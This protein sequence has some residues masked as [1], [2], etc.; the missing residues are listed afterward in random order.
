[1][2][3]QKVVLVTG[4]SSGLGQAAAAFLAQQSF[5][6][7]GTS[8][9]PASAQ[10][11]GVT[12]LPLDVTDA[13]SIRACVQ[14][15]IEQA[16][17]LDV[18]I[19]NAGQSGP[20][21]ASEEASIEQARAL[22]ETNF[23]GAMQVVNAV[24]PFMRRQHSGQIINIS[25]VAGI[26]AAPP[27]F[28]LYTASKYAL[29]AYT[30]VLRYEIAPFNIRVSLMELGYFK[31][32]IDQS[33]WPAEAPL[34]D[35][36]PTRQRVAEID[37]RAIQRGHDPALFAHAV[38]RIIRSP[39]PRLR[40]QVGSDAVTAQIARRFLPFSLI[41]RWIR[42]LYLEPDQRPGGLQA[43]LKRWMIDNQAIDAAQPGLEL[44]LLA[45]GALALGLGLRRIG[46]KRR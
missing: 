4:A 21:A 14:Q 25:S 1:M 10:V 15:V 22:F 20:A 40:Y 29:E 34:D 42:W 33:I 23:F 35:Y 8:R 44:G 46:R 18:L 17:C 6:V 30:E 13:C 39:T 3:D 12:M 31:T 7:F 41:E 38:L 24:L 36:A 32:H 28:G 19:N 43:S 26:I 37:A 27:F 11:D 16:G 5:R 45:A 9:R 2:P